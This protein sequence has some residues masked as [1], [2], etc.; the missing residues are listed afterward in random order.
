MAGALATDTLRV[1]L[2]DPTLRCVRAPCERS[3]APRLGTTV[4]AALADVN[5][6]VPRAACDA[7]AAAGGDGARQA[8]VPALI[9]PH[10]GVRGRALVALER[11]AGEELDRLLTSYLDAAAT[12]MRRALLEILGRRAQTGPLLRFVSD[13]SADVRL[14]VVRG[15][16][17][18]RS[19]ACRARRC[20]RAMIPSCS[21]LARQQPVLPR[22]PLKRSSSRGWV[23]PIAAGPHIRRLGGRAAPARAGPDGRFATA[24]LLLVGF[25][26]AKRQRDAMK[27]A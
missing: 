25:V 16:S 1:L 19:A 6:H 26:G 10:P 20:R 4:I 8:L 9:D 27:L 23:C 12:P 14:T 24:K 17:A 5:W 13:R 15:L 18:D 11:L 2:G 7:V 21:P 22:S 3:H